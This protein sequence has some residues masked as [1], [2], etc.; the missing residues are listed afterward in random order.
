M[1]YLAVLTTLLLGATATPIRQRQ[2]TQATISGFSA[3]TNTN[4]NGAAIG[5]DVEIAGVVNT[6]CSYSDETSGSKLPDIQQTPCDN[7]VVRWQ[8]R[9][10]PSQP[11]SEGRYRIVVI[12]APASGASAAGFH[13][14]AP[15][16]FPLGDDSE[17]V[18]QGASGFVVD[19]S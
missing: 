9:Q 7:P 10:D 18:Y 14:W 11:G 19:M 12:Y 16:D 1:K 8:F 17:T 3:S 6:H 4:G 15:S 5:Y 2:I 13:E